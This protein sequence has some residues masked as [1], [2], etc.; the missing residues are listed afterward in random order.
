M[1]DTEKLSSEEKDELI[2]RQTKKI[3]RYKKDLVSTSKNMQTL[4][5]LNAKLEQFIHL[6]PQEEQ[7]SYYTQKE[8]VSNSAEYLKKEYY[9]SAMYRHMVRVTGVEKDHIK[10]CLPGWDSKVDFV[11]EKHTIPEEILKNMVMDFRCYAYV[12]ALAEH[13]EQIFFEDWEMS[14]KKIKHKPF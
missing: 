7:A 13:A 14:G 10:V 2:L 12:P 8:S 9:S 5:E 11:L 1:S 3:T 4:L 6:L